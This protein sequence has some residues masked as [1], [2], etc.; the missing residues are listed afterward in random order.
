VRL[1]QSAGPCCGF[2]RM[3]WLWFESDYLVSTQQ[4]SFERERRLY[5]PAALSL[6]RSNRRATATLTCSGCPRN[7]THADSEST[8]T[9]VVAITKM[10]I[11]GDHHNATVLSGRAGR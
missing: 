7:S 4:I 3:L 2:V 9:V 6:I 10:Q 8:S 11:M 5:E 1:A